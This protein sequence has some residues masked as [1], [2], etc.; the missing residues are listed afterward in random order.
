MAI[1]IM[2]AHDAQSAAGKNTCNMADRQTPL[3][4]QG[5]IDQMT[6]LLNHIRTNKTMEQ[7][8]S[9]KTHTEITLE[10]GIAMMQRLIKPIAPIKITDFDVMKEMTRR[11][12]DIAMTNNLQQLQSSKRG[13]LVTIGVDSLTFKRLLADQAP[14][15]N[16]YLIGFYVVNKDQYDQVKQEFLNK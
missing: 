8:I 5:C 2:T 11:D 9:S 15:S 4:P 10:N 16:K 13:G 1:S 7:Q 12:M 6:E 3:T 14:G